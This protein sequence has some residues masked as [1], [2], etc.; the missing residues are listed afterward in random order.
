MAQAIKEYNV[1]DLLTNLTSPKK[2]GKETSGPTEYDV[3]DFFTNLQPYSA[4]EQP[5]TSGG[6]GKNLLKGVEYFSKGG[7]VGAYIQGNAID[8]NAAQ[9]FV[10]P[11]Q[12]MSIEDWKKSSL[13]APM[14]EYSV[15][16]MY[17]GSGFDPEKAKEQLIQKGKAFY[18]GGKEF[19]SNPIENLGTAA[20]TVAQNP[21]GFAGEVV[22]STVYDPEQIGAGVIGAKVAGKAISPVKDYFVK[23]FEDAKA[24]LTPKVPEA[25]I[26]APSA[27]P[28]GAPGVVAQTPR[29]VEVLDPN[30]GKPIV[31]STS[32]ISATGQLTEPMVKPAVVPEAAPMA[33]PVAQTTRNI[34]VL[35][36]NPPRPEAPA[37]PENISYKQQLLNDIGL[38]DIRQSALTGDPL[39]AS[40][41]YITSKADK[42]PYAQG[43]RN[44]IE[45]EKTTLGTHF[46][47]IE[48]E[49]GGTV[50]RRGTSFEVSDEMAR[51]KTIK[52]SLDSAQQ[53]HKAKTTELYNKASEQVGAVPVELGGFKE[54]LDKK[55]NFVKDPEKSLRN[56]IDDYL[57]EQGLLNPDKTVKPMTVGQSELLRQFINDQYDHTTSRKIGELVNR[58]DDDVFKNVQG[59][60]Y[61]Q[62][63]AHFRA[64]KE[65]YDNP[66]AIKDLMSDEGVNQ[67]IADEKVINKISNIDESQFG[68][69]MST[70]RET[71]KTEAIKEIQTALV[72]R[73]KEAGRSEVT[74]PWNARAAAKERAKLSEKLNVAFADNPQLLDKIDKG[75]EAGNVLYIPNKY[76]GAAVQTN[77]LHGKFAD[78]VLR[79]TPTAIGGFLGG[80]PGAVGGEMLGEKLSNAAAISRQKKL[81]QKEIKSKGTPLNEID[82]FKIKD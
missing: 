56:G 65:I 39:E 4:S 54:F 43:I 62:A 25:P 31:A 8:P 10:K 77:L 50:P 23:S 17:P 64:G 55:S 30:T 29:M 1:D 6:F 2:A 72:N 70:L 74:E 28:G 33:A 63:R 37:T 49:L 42:G 9:K 34:T 76:P 75:I 78:F 41:Q 53:A 16:S 71:G 26:V 21:Y 19:L 22:K 15:G 32:E 14:I 79:K 69:L 73:V 36:E 81:L 27:T 82:E 20:K 45:L 58:I 46:G 5:V 67:K 24:G 68:H 12:E 80:G 52:D 60:T 47:S 7:P 3:N 18:Q 66:K 44:Q 40:S 51:G 11:L 57:S 13:L 35:D 38:D 61:E 59:D 48:S